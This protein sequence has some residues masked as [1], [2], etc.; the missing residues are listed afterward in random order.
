MRHQTQHRSLV[1]LA[2]S[3]NNS[4]DLKAQRQE[5][6]KGLQ[7]SAKQDSAG[8]YEANAVAIADIREPRAREFTGRQPAYPEY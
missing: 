3:N 1:S 4:N 8:R 6:K 7:F 5:N 2:L